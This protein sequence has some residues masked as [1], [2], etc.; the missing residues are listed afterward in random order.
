MAVNLICLTKKKRKMKNVF[1]ALFVSSIFVFASCG[2][3]SAEEQKRMEDS[4]VNAL[5]Q[6][7]DQMNVALDSVETTLE[8]D[9]TA[10]APE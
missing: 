10:V 1:F 6:A 7:F 8:V 2:G 9:T 4:L 5:N 3:P